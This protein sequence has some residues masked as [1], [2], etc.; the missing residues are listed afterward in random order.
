MKSLII[1]IAILF[2][3]LCFAQVDSALDNT[4]PAQSQP[5][6]SDVQ[7]ASATVNND[8]LIKPKGMWAGNASKFFQGAAIGFLGHESGHLIANC[9]LNTHL[10]L[11]SVNYGPIPFFTI[12]PGKPLN[13]REH[14]ITASAGFNAQNI[15]NECILTQHPNLSA[16]DE[17]TL[18]GIASFNFWLAAG[19][20]ASAFTKTG[21][22]ERDTKGMADSLGWNERWIGVMIL[23][24]TALDTY[25]YKH[26]DA[27]W[28]VTASRLSKLAMIAL[29]LDAED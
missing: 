6:A 15:I 17:P 20:A 5:A 14:Y 9:A 10:Y 3:T 23:V 2:P 1:T 22:D 18:K 26:P 28:A 19:Y 4:Q 13:H 7:L 12:E 27:K 16:E 11:K 21:P 8:P 25:R 24:P 29:A